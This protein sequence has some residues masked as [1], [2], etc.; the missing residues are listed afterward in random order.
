MIKF[1]AKLLAAVALVQSMENHRQSICGVY[2]DGQR[3]VA[4]DGHVLNVAHDENAIIGTPGIYPISKKAIAAAKWRK[5][6]V[7]KISDGTLYVYGENPKLILHME[8]C[9]PIDAEY[10]DYKRII[11]TTL[12]IQ[13]EIPAFTIPVMTHVTN[14]AKIVSLSKIKLIGESDHGAHVVRYDDPRIFSVVMPCRNTIP[15]DLPEWF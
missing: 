2:L 8:S 5:A 15:T 4:T 11:P 10:P 9:V 1:D 13:D 3:A 14:T 6:T 12:T 7:V